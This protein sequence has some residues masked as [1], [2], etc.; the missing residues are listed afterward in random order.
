MEHQTSEWTT[1][2]HASFSIYNTT[3]QIR[4]W[5]EQ[6]L[7]DFCSYGTVRRKLER[8]ESEGWQKNLQGID[9]CSK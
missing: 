4:T 3:Y 5:I 6:E 7:E 1:E 8:R 2:E 9:S